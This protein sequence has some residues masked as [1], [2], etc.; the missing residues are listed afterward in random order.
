MHRTSTAP[1]RGRGLRA[2]LAAASALAVGLTAALLAGPAAADAGP[3]VELP[4]GGLSVTGETS[5]IHDPALVVADDGTWY[6]YST[7]LVNR[8]KGGTIQVWSSGDD[9]VTWESEGTVWDEIPA[10]IDE[11]FADGALPDNLW[12]PEVYEHDGTYYLYYSASRFGTNTSLT[13]LATNTTLDPDD[14]DYE[15][16]DQGLVIESPQDIAGAKTF[17]AIDAGI[18]EDADGTPYMA[19]GSHWYGIFLVE[20]AWPSGKPVAGAVADAVH[21]VDRFAP[22]NRVEAPFITEHDGWYY[23]LVSFD[24]CCQGADSTYHVAVGRSR[25]VTGPYLDAEGRDMV[26]GGGTTLLDTHGAVVGPGGQSVFDDVLA[27]HYYDASNA[28]F[29]YLPTLGL[30]RLAWVDGWPV[31]D[32]TVEVPAVLSGPQD[33]DVALG[34]AATFAV[35]VSGTPTPVVTWE[36]SRDGGSTWEQAAPGRR[37]VDGSASLEL[38]AVGADDDGLLA[39][40]IVQNAHGSVVSPTASLAVTEAVALGDVVAQ[41]RCL[42]G[43][44]YLAVRATSASTEPVT[45]A[46][47]TPYGS[48]TV[49]G[50]APGRSAYQAFAVRSSEVAEGSVTVTA[51]AGERAVSRTVEHAALTCP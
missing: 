2:L 15:W 17:N 30:Q 40:A 12:A 20:I 27:F 23:L 45:I 4:T 43:S 31:V 29:P 5:P 28:Q 49:V 44:A 48:R 26:G 18:V 34:D 39:R 11:H 50:V 46:L 33:A 38:P 1:T 42:G 25:S 47:S 10:W 16:V 9:G 36:T 41:P 13:A 35:D 14:P 24:A 37:A 21:L 19:I 51:T 3:A 8:E 32:A 6:V 22:G 7:G